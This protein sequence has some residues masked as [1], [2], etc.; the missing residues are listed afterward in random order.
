M[1]PW[2]RWCV[3]LMNSRRALAPELGEGAGA[4]QNYSFRLTPLAGFPK[5]LL[6]YPPGGFSKPI[7]VK[8]SSHFT[9]I[10]S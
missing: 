9:L 6:V 8:R 2:A 4:G 7:I 3:A 10:S 1:S 5:P